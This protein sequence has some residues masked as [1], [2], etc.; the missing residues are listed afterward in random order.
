MVQRELFIQD[1]LSRAQIYRQKIDSS[2]PKNLTN[3]MGCLL[4][5]VCSV[6]SMVLSF[7]F[8]CDL[9]SVQ[10]L[11]VIGK[12]QQS[13]HMW[14]MVCINGDYYH[15]DAVYN[16]TSK[17]N[18]YLNVDDRLMLRDRSLSQTFSVPKAVEMK[19]NYF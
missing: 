5:R 14:N 7:K 4:D 16:A 18:S 13:D 10:C 11:S 15:V 1:I 19:E 6:Q 2:S 8:L 9:L 12:I 3:I 17:L